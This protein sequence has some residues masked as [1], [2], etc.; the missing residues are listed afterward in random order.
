MMTEP[1][2][3][4]SFGAVVS[5]GGAAATSVPGCPAAGGV[6]GSSVLG[7]AGCAAATS[8]P[9]AVLAGGDATSSVFG[10]AG[11]PESAGAA[12][13]SGSAA[14]TAGGLVAGGFSAAELS[15]GG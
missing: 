10:C 14:A 4:T 9:G 11:C 15:A 1:C 6:A 8:V 2:A 13:C 7:S 3:L 5:G 12:G